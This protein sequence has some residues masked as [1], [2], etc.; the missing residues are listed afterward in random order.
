VQAVIAPGVP[1]A[2]IGGRGHAL[3]VTRERGTDRASASARVPAVNQTARAF[4]AIAR[5]QVAVPTAERY[6]LE[7]VTP[8]VPMDRDLVIVWRPEIGATPVLAALSETQG[9]TTYALLML[10]PPPSAATT[11]SAQP[12]EQIFVIDTSGSMGGQSI[13]Q[14]KA[15]L[16]D[17]LGRLRSADRF[18]VFQFNTHTSSLFRTPMPF[19]QESYTEAL[20]Y[21]E[22]LRATGGTEIESAIRA[23]LA[24]PTTSGYVRQIVFMT[25]GAVGGETRLF[26]A[27]KQNLGDARLFTIGIGSAPNANFM[28]KAAQ[29]GR[30]TFTYIGN[31]A[32]VASKMQALFEKLEHVALTDVVV[33][34]PE[35]AEFYP[36]QMPDLYAGEPLVVAASFPARADRAVHAQAWG[37]GGGTRWSQTVNASASELPGIA[38]LWARRKI[39]YVIDSRVDGIPESLIRTLVT[40]TALAHHLVSPYTSLVAVD[41]TPAR[42]AAAALERRQVMNNVP[43]GTQWTLALPSTATNAP[44]YRELGFLLWM[45]AALA[46]VLG[47]CR[48]HVRA[49][50]VSR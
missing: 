18:N 44:L 46:V 45:L 25:D 15:A 9:D 47:A 38:A 17:A 40:E 12:R 5:P 33:D 4:G 48:R 24:Q 14:A 36:N 31:T 50:S 32:E 23:S 10:L 42:S 11:P 30:G 26:S 35:A 16:T 41:Q 7:T 21:V 27:I 34:W 13:E 8:R 20:R 28:R 49:P 37:A 29:F 43:D 3:R 2:E 39:E 22:G 19:T 6:R 1:L